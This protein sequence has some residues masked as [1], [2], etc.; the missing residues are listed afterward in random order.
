MASGEIPKGDWVYAVVGVGTAVFVGGGAN[1]GVGCCRLPGAS[2][3]QAERTTRN[4]SQERILNPI[5]ERITFLGIP[6][7]HWIFRSL[8]IQSPP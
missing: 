6:D 5:L 4:K 2:A 3:L 8:L 1:V 7:I